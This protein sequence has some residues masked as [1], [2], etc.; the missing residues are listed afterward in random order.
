[1]IEL[2]IHFHQ[3]KRFNWFYVIQCCFVVI[4]LRF[5][6]ASYGVDECNRTA[7]PMLM[8]SEPMDCCSTIS[9]YVNIQQNTAKGKYHV[10]QF[11]CISKYS[12]LTFILKD[13]RH[14]HFKFFNAYYYIRT[15]LKLNR[16]IAM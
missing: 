14:E 5:T 12:K 10:L 1:M 9:V 8:L 7:Q 2:R 11:V 3:V 4:T 16:C 13:N 15:L 6:N